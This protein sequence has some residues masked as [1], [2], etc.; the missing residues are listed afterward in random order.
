MYIVLLIQH[1]NAIHA[2]TN[3]FLCSNCSLLCVM[4]G[5][6]RFYSFTVSDYKQLRVYQ[7]SMHIVAN[8]T[9]HQLLW[10]L[11]LIECVLQY[12]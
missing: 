12:W 11:E 5:S 3:Y 1:C 6:Y 9:L 4:A 7:V 2:I 8:S 10:G